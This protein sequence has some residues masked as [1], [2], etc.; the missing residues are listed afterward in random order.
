[1]DLVVRLVFDSP[2]NVA[3][4]IGSRAAKGSR[5]NRGKKRGSLD[6]FRNTDRSLIKS[7]GHEL[8]ASATVIKRIARRTGS[9]ITVRISENGRAQSLRWISIVPVRKAEAGIA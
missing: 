7:A 9:G 1:M 4:T 5:C 8:D 6:G 2:L 3:A